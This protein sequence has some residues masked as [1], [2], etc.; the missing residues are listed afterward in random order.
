[1]AEGPIDANVISGLAHLQ[2]AVLEVIA[3]ARVAL[4]VAEELIK[5]PS[6][7]LSAVQ[8]VAAPSASP[9]PSARV[10]HINIQ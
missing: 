2:N 4:D 1:M 10:E 5:D 8:N 3:A 6:P 7:L 9:K